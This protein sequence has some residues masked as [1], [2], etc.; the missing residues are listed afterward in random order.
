MQNGAD[1]YDVLGVQRNAT[2]EEIRRSFRKLAMEWHPDRNNG[3]EAEERFKAI[4]E[5][6][7]V[8]IDPEKRRLYDRFG[9]VDVGVAE[10][11]PGRGFEGTGFAGGVGDIF[12]AFFGGFGVERETGPRRGAD[13]HFTLEISFQEAV[14]GTNKEV[15]VLRTE[16][17]SRCRGSRAAPGSKAVTCANC[18]GTGQVRRSQSGFFGQF[19]QVVTCSVC[20][21]EGKA[22]ET[23]CPQCNGVGRER[24]ARHLRVA[25]PAGVED[26]MQVR[27]TGE[28]EAGWNGGPAGSVYITLKAGEH[29]LYRRRGQDLVLEIPVNVAQ[30]AL[31]DTIEIPLLDGNTEQ[32]KIPAGV[33]PGTI[34]R[35]KGKGVPSVS[36]GRRG[37]L[38]GVV[39][40]MTPRRLD[41]RSRKLF[42]ELAKILDQEVPDTGNGSRTWT[43]KVKDAKGSNGD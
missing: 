14:F 8:L 16:L 3:K 26:G 17:C 38:L 27:L 11:P 1:L 24:H 7:Q 23:P 13:L 4:N 6:Y 29:P 10:W 39:Q 32:V 19:V 9:R 33:Q 12:D 22:V 15:D 37:D 34:L 31:G 25:I 21:G 35:V 36:N 43:Q 28:G 42:Q 41:P 5:A 30:A 18:R 20:R 40:V 2:E